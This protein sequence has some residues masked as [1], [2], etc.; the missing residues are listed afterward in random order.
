MVAQTGGDLSAS[1][2][3]GQQRAQVQRGVEGLSGQEQ[4]QT[5][6]EHP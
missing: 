1:I 5:R 4:N 6:G 3:A 2:C